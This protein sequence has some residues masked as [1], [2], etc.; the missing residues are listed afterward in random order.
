MNLQTASDVLSIVTSAAVATDVQVAFENIAG[1][2]S[3]G[4]GRVNAAITAAT[5][6]PILTYPAGLAPAVRKVKSITVRNKGVSSQTVTLVHTDGTTSVELVEAVLGADEQLVYTDEDAF[7][8]LDASGRL[9]TSATTNQ[10]AGAVTTTV[11]GSDVSNAEAVANTITNVTG[12]SFDVLPGKMY[13]FKFSGVY[14]SAVDTTGARFAVNGPAATYLAYTSEYTLTTTTTTRNANVSAYDSPA[15]AAAT[16]VALGG[17]FTV[18]G[19]V[20]P[21][22][23]GTVILRFASEVTV[24]AVTV[25]AGSKVDSARLN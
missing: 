24:S 20:Q 3:Q 18:E 8:V 6:T 10:L 11:L 7:R 4:G 17:F 1:G 22:A 13:W 2:T 25:K 5:T 12:L 19:Y 15:A 16:S 21:S 23:A 9:K 14:T